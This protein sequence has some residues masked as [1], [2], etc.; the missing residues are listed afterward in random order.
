MKLK[1]LVKLNEIKEKPFKI[2]IHNCCNNEVCY[3]G[4]SEYLAFKEKEVEDWHITGTGNKTEN[5]D[6]EIEVWI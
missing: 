4:V 5:D 2:L 6:Y 1:I 3:L